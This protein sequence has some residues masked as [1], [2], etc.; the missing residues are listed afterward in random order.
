MGAWSHEPFGNDNACD[1]AYGL[2][3]KS[4]YSTIE[5]AFDQ[6]IKAKATEEY[7]DADYSTEAIAAAYA[8][9]KAS[10]KST[11]EDAYTNH[12]DEWVKRVQEKPSV[13]LVNKAQ[14]A[15]N[16]ALTEDSEL[17]E[18]WAETEDLGVWKETVTDLI[19]KL[20]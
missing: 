4:D 12:V 3:D 6:I 18:L 5:E 19:E 1:W 13:E 2:K 8:L 11:A 16:L 20:K 7:L 17:Y 9:V 10:G 14:I 15:L